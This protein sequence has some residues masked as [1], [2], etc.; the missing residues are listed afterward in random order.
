MLSA[1]DLLGLACSP[2]IWAKSSSMANNLGGGVMSE[3]S[4]AK[5]FILMTRSVLISCAKGS[6]ANDSG[7][8]GHTRLVPLPI[9]IADL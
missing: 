5:K 6:K 3:M 7:E 4:S 2:E 9:T 1:L 8:R